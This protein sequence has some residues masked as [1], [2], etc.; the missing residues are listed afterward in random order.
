[1]TQSVLVIRAK[2]FLIISLSHFKEENNDPGFS[3]SFQSC[4][5]SITPDC[6]S[7]TRPA[8]FPQHV[9]RHV[10]LSLFATQMSDT[11]ESGSQ[12]FFGATVQ[13]VFPCQSFTH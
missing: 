12:G 2:S 7:P 9:P 10:N 11:S 8:S 6:R 13:G 5:P 1:M 3:F 4:I